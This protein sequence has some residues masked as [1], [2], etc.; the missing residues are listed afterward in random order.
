MHF[1]LKLAIPLVHCAGQIKIVVE[2]QA[3]RF[4][5]LQW[6]IVPVFL[7]ERNLI[8]FEFRGK[9][10]ERDRSI[11]I[12]IQLFEEISCLSFVHV[13]VDGLQEHLETMEIQILIF[14]QIEI[15]P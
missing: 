9:L 2:V 11:S 6:D 14:F 7:S 4:V 5:D 3:V 15:L 10:F 1:F 12:D 8:F 13:G